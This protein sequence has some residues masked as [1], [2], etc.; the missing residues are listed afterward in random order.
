MRG[1]VMMEGRGKQKGMERKKKRAKNKQWEREAESNGSYGNG[2]MNAR[3]QELS[4]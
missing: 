3:E 2:E 1:C 4:R